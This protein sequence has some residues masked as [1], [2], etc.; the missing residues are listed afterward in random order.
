MYQKYLVSTTKIVA[1]YSFFFVVMKII[2]VL[3]GK[4]MAANL[5]TTIPF[6]IIGFW[7]AYCVFAEKF[8]WIITIIFVLIIIVFRIYEFDVL[9]YLQE[10]IK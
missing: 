5:M 3:L 2:S 4:P 1:I 6:L 10:N 7:S 9:L 8:N